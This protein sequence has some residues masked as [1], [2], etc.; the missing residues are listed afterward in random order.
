VLAVTVGTVQK[1]ALVLLV[2]QEAFME[3]VAVEVE[4]V[5]LDSLLAVVAL[6]LRVV[7]FSRFGM[8]NYDFS[9]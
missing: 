3:V 9:R 6:V 4:P 7:F 2:V 8:N 1:V 5:L